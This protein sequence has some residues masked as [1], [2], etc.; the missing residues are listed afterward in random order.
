LVQEGK[1]QQEVPV[2]HD[3]DDDY[4]DEGDDDDDDNNVHEL[5]IHVTVPRYR[6]LF[7]N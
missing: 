4:Y 6:F 1:H 2:T 5:Y 3:D 7:N